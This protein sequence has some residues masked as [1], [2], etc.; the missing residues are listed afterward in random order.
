[1]TSPQPASTNSNRFDFSAGGADD[2]GRLSELMKHLDD[3]LL[4][5]N[6]E[7]ITRKTLSRTLL[8]LKKSIGVELARKD[9][10]VSLATLKTIRLIFLADYKS[11]RNV[12]GL[13]MPPPIAA[14]AT[15]E[16]ATI[17]T[18]HRD[19]A[20]SS[21]IQA[22]CDSLAL[23]ID[24][25]RVRILSNM[26]GNFDGR[27]VAE[28]FVLR[29]ERINS[30]VLHIL[31]F[32]FDQNDQALAD[33]LHWMA[34]LMK[35][36]VPDRTSQGLEPTHELMY[37]YLQ[38]LSI[39]HF[40]HHYPTHLEESRVQK[41][42]GDIRHEVKQ[43]LERMNHSRPVHYSAM[44]PILPIALVGHFISEWSEH[45]SK[46]VHK[47]TGSSTS[48]RK[49]RSIGARA[50]RVLILHAERFHGCTDQ[51]ERILSLNDVIAALSAVRYQQATGSKYK[52]YWY[53]QTDQGDSPQALFDLGINQTDP[54]QHQG[55]LQVFLNPF[56][57]YRAAFNAT[58]ASHHA[59]MRYQVATLGA[60]Q[61]VLDLGD[62]FEVTLG[63][64]TL[65]FHCINAAKDLVIA[66]R[67]THT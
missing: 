29:M 28:C 49:L 65:K 25:A 62:I 43:L 17:T 52:P 47:A 11:N 5:A 24:P 66:S 16:F 39:R 1:M 41:D 51:A 22:I 13:L 6:G 33:A 58:Q 23:E 63:L 36:F 55:V 18:F 38:T 19:E 14:K 8:L 42:I 53:G 44:T 3:E 26:L 50:T 7:Q 27:S 9:E 31:S 48:A 34:G 46:L 32:A 60:Y 2:S 57:D 40:T 30:E 15:M 56:Y 10:P 35:K 20:A 37:S 12:I 59:W 61:S 67:R 54:Y 4:K 64:S 21:L 45:L